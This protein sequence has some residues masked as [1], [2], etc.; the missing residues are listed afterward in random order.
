M[1][2]LS[3]GAMMPNKNYQAG[4]RM[5]YESVKRWRAKGYDANR[6]AGSH[7]HWDVV[8]VR[9][10]RSVEL[11]QCKVVS[12]EASAIRLLKKFTEQPPFLP[13]ERYHQVLE[14]KVK[15]DTKIHSITV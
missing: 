11:V 3:N 15:G 2:Y 5:E 6:S 1:C 4:R 13:S 8:A 9:S 12:D 10:G 7:G 14:V